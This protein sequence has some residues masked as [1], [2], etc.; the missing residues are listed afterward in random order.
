LNDLI[1]SVPISIRAPIAVVNNLSRPARIG[2]FVLCFLASVVV[3]AGAQSPPAAPST[4]VQAVYLTPGDV[5]RIAIWREEDLSGE[6]PV[7]ENGFVT[8][9]LLGDHNV[10]EIP[11]H[12]L[13]ETLLEGYRTY[14]RNPSISITPLRRINVLGEVNRPGSFEVDPTASLIGVVGMAGGPT[15]AANLRAVRVI[16]DG[17]VVHHEANPEASLSSLGLRSGD[18]V[19]VV[20]RNWFARNTPF[21]ISVLLA[22]P[23][24]IYTLT[25]LARS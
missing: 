9:P 2:L 22:V 13:R 23:S 19:Y 24:V 21:L 16:R 8:L 11:L 25:L 18:Q 15:E 4:G 12:R 17:S 10:A 14:L 1:H 6:F 20:P 3:P 5:I 7:D